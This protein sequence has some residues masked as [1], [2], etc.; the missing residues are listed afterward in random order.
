MQR[1]KRIK[2][3]GAIV[4]IIIAAITITIFSCKITGTSSKKVAD[5]EYTVVEDQDIPTEL[6]K[7]IDEKKQ[8]SLRL[9]YTTKDYI[10]IVAG[11]G[12]QPTSGYSIRLNEIY[13]GQNA[14]YIDTN[15]IGPSKGEEVNE[16]E[17]YPYIVIMI[18][19]RDDPVVFNIS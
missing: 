18:E 6:M 14:I 5:L 8:N 19:K 15:L 12:T 3:Y 2:L 4:L 11:Y 9:T 17:T 10:Y 16:K 1:N 7:I 13:L